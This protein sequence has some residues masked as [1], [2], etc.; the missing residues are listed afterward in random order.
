VGAVSLMVTTV[1]LAGVVAVC[2]CTQ[3]VSPE[4]CQVLVHHS[5]IGADCP[6]DRV[7]PIVAYAIVAYAN[8]PGIVAG[9]SQRAVGAP[10]AALLPPTMPIAPEP[11]V[12][13][14]S[15]S[16][17]PPPAPAFPCQ[18]ASDHG[19]AYC[20]GPALRGHPARERRRI[21]NRKSLPGS[22]D[23]PRLL[24]RRNCQSSRN[25]R[26]GP[27][28]VALNHR[29]QVRPAVRQPECGKQLE[30]SPSFEKPKKT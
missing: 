8:D 27:A 19:E 11:P 10:E 29:G 26:P 4:R 20:D 28:G 7:L 12:P 30:H 13:E 16:N 23:P 21:R 17:A 15:R 1:P 9:R 22:G 3:Y 6:A 18:R 25:R 24:P 2:H 14:G 5:L